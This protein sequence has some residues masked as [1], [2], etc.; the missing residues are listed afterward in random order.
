MHR[1]SNTHT[2]V[3]WTPVPNET[4]IG[5]SLISLARH[6]GCRL[7]VSNARHSGRTTEVDICAVFADLQKIIKGCLTGIKG[8]TRRIWRLLFVNTF[9]VV[10][11]SRLSC[12]RAS[13]PMC[14]HVGGSA[15]CY[16]PAATQGWCPETSAKWENEAE[17]TDT[18]TDVGVKSGDWEEVYAASLKTAFLLF[19]PVRFKLW[20]TVLCL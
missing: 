3:P 15:H 4:P 12:T 6:L 1:H 14:P 2:A 11:S 19:L 10:S 8:R 7:G 20:Q 13:S 16:Q 17:E 18:L 5:V 9:K